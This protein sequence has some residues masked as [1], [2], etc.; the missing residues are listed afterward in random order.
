MVNEEYIRA[1]ARARGVELTEEQVQAAL[2]KL[3]NAP[4]I[5]PDQVLSL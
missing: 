3:R 4:Q 5:T 2:H 1:V